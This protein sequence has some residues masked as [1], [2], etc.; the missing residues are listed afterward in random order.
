MGLRTADF[1]SELLNVPKSRVYELVRQDVLPVVRIGVRQ[2]RFD[3]KALEEWIRNGGTISDT[4]RTN[5]DNKKTSAARSVTA[6][7]NGSV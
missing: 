2:I 1:V 6:L 4:E 7:K 3:Q 5:D